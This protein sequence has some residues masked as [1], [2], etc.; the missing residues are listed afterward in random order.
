MGELSFLQQIVI[1]G[2]FHNNKMRSK[3][4]GTALTAVNVV[5]SSMEK[6]TSM[7]EKKKLDVGPP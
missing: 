1:D 6:K 5:S 4:R 2:K 3:L 7:E